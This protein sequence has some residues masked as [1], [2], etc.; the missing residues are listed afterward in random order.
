MGVRHY[1]DLIAWQLAVGFS[2][3]V[4]GLV[5]ASGRA[6]EDVPFRNQLLGAAESVSSNVA[7]GFM[8]YSRPEFR[9]FLDYALGSLAEAETRLEHGI[10][11]GYFTADDI[12]RA[13]RL[14][15]RC[16][17][18]MVR[19]KQSQGGAHP[20]YPSSRS[21]PSYPSYPEKK[22]GPK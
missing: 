17:T 5:R 2:A 21:R 15:R 18:A 10:A 11:R 16:L 8:R 12:T 3:E 6:S 22:E 13:N 9:R 14:A 20:S 7:E 1:R 19:L 4:A